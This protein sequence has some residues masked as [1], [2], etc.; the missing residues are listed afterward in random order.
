MGQMHIHAAHFLSL[1]FSLVLVTYWWA[2]LVILTRFLSFLCHVGPPCLPFFHLVTEPRVSP[3][4]RNKLS[5]PCAERREMRAVAESPP[6]SRFPSAYKIIRTWEPP[7]YH[8]RRRGEDRSCCP[9][10]SAPP[11]AEP[12]ETPSGS[13]ITG[14]RLSKGAPRTCG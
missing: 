10:N 1:P 9:T 3:L 7:P 13:W 5:P 2:Q 6:F 8:H 12:G 11:R 4:T 14:R